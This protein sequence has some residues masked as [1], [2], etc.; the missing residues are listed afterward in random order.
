MIYL[1]FSAVQLL[2]IGFRCFG[3][4]WSYRIYRIFTPCS[5]SGLVPEPRRQRSEADSF[6]TGSGPRCDSFS[7]SK[8]VVIAIMR[9]RQGATASR[10]T[11]RVHWPYR[12]ACIADMLLAAG[13]SNTGSQP[14]RQ[15]AFKCA[16]GIDSHALPPRGT[17]LG[18]ADAVQSPGLKCSDRAY[19]W[20]LM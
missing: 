17:S 6:Q 11:E 2:T 16:R 19:W 4:R 5:S 20:P 10:F 1:P 13:E 3:V 15:R 7:I 8:L 12:S 18:C 14:R 9:I